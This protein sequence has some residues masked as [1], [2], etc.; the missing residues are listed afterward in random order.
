M[1]VRKEKVYEY[2]PSYLENNDY[3]LEMF[4]HLSDGFEKLNVTKQKGGYY[5]FTPFNMPFFEYFPF[6]LYV[7][8]TGTIDMCSEINAYV[9]AN[10][11]LIENRSK[12]TILIE[13]DEDGSYSVSTRKIEIPSSPLVTSSQKKQSFEKRKYSSSGALRQ[14]TIEEYQP[15]DINLYDDDFMI[16]NKDVNVSKSSVYH[17]LS[18]DDA[19][20]CEKTYD[21]DLGGIEFCPNCEEKKYYVTYKDGEEASK[22]EVNDTLYQSYMDRYYDVV[23]DEKYVSKES[24]KKL[25]KT[26]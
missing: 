18:T 26:I 13:K 3:F 25:N 16:W 24:F 12:T 9:R 21:S 15:Q 17:Y 23:Y 5:F 2:F 4:Q 11:H 14:Y 7:S 19:I 8:K 22:I 6:A 1:E 20:V 10:G